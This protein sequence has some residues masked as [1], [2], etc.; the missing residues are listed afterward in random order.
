LA[1][2]VNQAEYAAYFEQHGMAQVQRHNNP[3]RDVVLKA[4]SFGSFAPSAVS[5]DKDPVSMEYQ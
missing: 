5:A 1:D 4:V 2:I 3:I